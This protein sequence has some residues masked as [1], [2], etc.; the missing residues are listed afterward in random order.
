[1]ETGDVHDG[2]IS[3]IDIIDNGLDGATVR[4]VGNS[5]YAGKGATWA[6]F[7]SEFVSIEEFQFKYSINKGDSFNSGGFMF[8]VV[9]TD[10]KLKGYLLSINFAGDF[11]SKAHNKNGAIFE[12]EYTK[13]NNTKNFEVLN[14]VEELKFG[15]YTG[16]RESSGQG[17]I[18][19]KVTDTGYIVHGTEL[20]KDYVI[21]VRYSTTRY[22]WLL[23]RPLLT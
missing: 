9:E 3:Y 13:G 14:L 2:S 8:N 4:M 19:I 11:Y 20:S 16:G 21:N 5:E 17:E 1:M 18:S 22:I 7:K 23:F 15:A 12:F 6:T 10:T